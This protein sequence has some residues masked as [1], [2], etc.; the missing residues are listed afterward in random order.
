MVKEVN[1]VGIRIYLGVGFGGAPSTDLAI[2]EIRASRQKNGDPVVAVRVSNT[3]GW[4]VDLT[5][6]LRLSDGQGRVSAR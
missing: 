1:R 4:A 5:G 6:H 2:R 3:G